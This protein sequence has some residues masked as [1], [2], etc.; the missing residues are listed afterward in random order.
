MVK[1][2]ANTEVPGVAAKFPVFRTGTPNKE[3]RVEVWW[4]WDGEKEWKIGRLKPG[5]EKYPIRGVWNDALLIKR[6]SEGWNHMNF[7]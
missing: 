6:I 4:L 1:I 5:M 2:V 3:G 7:I